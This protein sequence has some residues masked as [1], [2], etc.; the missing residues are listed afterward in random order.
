MSG[1]RC[2]QAISDVNYND[3]PCIMPP[4]GQSSRCT[5]HSSTATA[6]ASDSA[7][8]IE[9]DKLQKY[10]SELWNKIP[11]LSEVLDLLPHDQCLIVEV[12]KSILLA[13]QYS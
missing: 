3:L 7:L 2:A 4:D 12:R 1:G 8:S 6:E 10:R 9:I 5:G 13:C 11:L